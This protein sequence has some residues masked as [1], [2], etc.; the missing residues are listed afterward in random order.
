[1]SFPEV[2]NLNVHSFTD[3]AVLT[4]LTA[5][6]IRTTRLLHRPQTVSSSSE[7]EVLSAVSSWSVG[8][9]YGRPECTS[10][11]PVQRECRRN[12]GTRDV[13]CGVKSCVDN[14]DG[15]SGVDSYMTCYFIAVVNY[16]TC[17]FLS[18]IYTF[19]TILRR[20]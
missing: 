13:P 15:V 17:L 8:S 11:W 3:D 5:V 18:E 9:V 20:Q 1:M 2:H 7:L 14:I 4:K 12:V 6:T 16:R 19:Y 10:L